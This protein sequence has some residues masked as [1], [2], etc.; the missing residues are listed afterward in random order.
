MET[1]LFKVQ[2]RDGEGRLVR[3]TECMRQREALRLADDMLAEGLESE[4]LR[5]RCDAG[6]RRRCGRRPPSLA[7]CPL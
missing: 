2:V 6:R 7:Q 1:P 4:V 5:T 3:R